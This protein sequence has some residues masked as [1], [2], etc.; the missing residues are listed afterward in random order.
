M[1]SKT[2]K[3]VRDLFIAGLPTWTA[4][5]LSAEGSD[6]Y[7]TAYSSFDKDTTDRITAGSS[8]VIGAVAGNVIFLLLR[9]LGNNAAYSGK[10]GLRRYRDDMAKTYLAKLIPDAIYLF[11]RPF[12]MNLYQR[13]GMEPW[14]ASLAADATLSVVYVPVATFLS[15]KLGAIREAPPAGG[16]Y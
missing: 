11:G 14:A 13:Q 2:G 6:R 16:S 1:V 12:V 3:F 15:N 9:R 10:G 5:A 4:N 7:L 8:T